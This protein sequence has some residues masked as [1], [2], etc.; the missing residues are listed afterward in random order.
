MLP[1]DDSGVDLSD[2]AESATVSEEEPER[3]TL[4]EE[5]EKTMIA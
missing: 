5:V 1:A 3:E 4:D 2:I